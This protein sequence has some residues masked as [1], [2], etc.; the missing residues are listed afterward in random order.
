[1]ANAFVLAGYRNQGI[2][3]RL[4]DAVL[5]HARQTVSPGWC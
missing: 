4:L 2:G 1:V 5:G 3:R